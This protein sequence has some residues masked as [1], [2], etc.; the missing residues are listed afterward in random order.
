MVGK[1]VLLFVSA[2]CVLLCSAGRVF[3]DFEEDAAKC[4]QIVAAKP[5]TDEAL[6][7]Q[8]KLVGLYVKQKMDAEAEAAYSA[9]LTDFAGNAGLAKAVDH[10]ADAYRESGK[11]EKALELYKQVVNN[12]PG[13]EHALE[14]QGA[15]ARLYIKIGDEPNAVAAVEQLIGEFGDKKESADVVDSVADEYRDCKRYAEAMELYRRVAEM[16]PTSKQACGSLASVAALYIKAGDD[17]NATTVTNNLIANFAANKGLGDAVHEIAYTYHH[18]VH[19]YEKARELYEWVVENRPSCKMAIRAQMGIAKIYVDLGDD[20]NAEAAIEKLVAKYSENKEIA[21]A[22]DRIADEYR[23]LERYDKAKKLYELVVS[24]WPDAEHSEDAL[25]DAT[26][27]DIEAHIAVG[28]DAN[29]MAEINEMVID[30][31][32]NPGLVKA[33]FQMGEKFYRKGFYYKNRE[34]I[35]RS[36]AAF[37]RAAAVWDIILERPGSFK[38]E[39]AYYF[40]AGCYRHLGDYMMA[41]EYYQVVVDGWPSNAKASVAQYRVAQ[42]YQEMMDTGQISKKDAL[43]GI[44]GACGNVIANYPDSAAFKAAEN[45]L[46]EIEVMESQ[47]K[48]EGGQ[49]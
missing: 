22:L 36:E 19:D 32:D 37:A 25:I 35:A 12:W 14:S 15:V 43:I 5:G 16:W 27:A 48:N 29:A 23:G 11:Y 13:A 4:K 6:K 38:K 39:D 26:K 33:L 18:R 46:K 40:S 9:M 41:A 1:K 49:E 45:T 21:K 3:A 10:V 47:A 31:N 17:A 2:G 42:C 7:A 8:E 28:D 44:C 20:P 30:F 34:D 24:R